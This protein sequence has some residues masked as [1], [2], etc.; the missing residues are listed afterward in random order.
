MSF[1]IYGLLGAG[2]LVMTCACVGAACTPDP[3]QRLH[4]LAP[5]TSLG[6]PLIGVALALDSGWQ[7]STGWIVVIVL[8][9]VLTGP[10]VQAAV[11]REIA[12]EQG[13]LRSEPPR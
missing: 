5:A 6:V 12:R 11:G 3:Y 4:F 13:R 2:V 7:L 1:V 9:L 8:L 10:V